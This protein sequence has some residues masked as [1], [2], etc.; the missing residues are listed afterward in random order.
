MDAIWAAMHEHLAQ[1][2]TE[3][4]IKAWITPLVP[5]KKEGPALVLGCP[6]RFFL[7]WIQEHYLTNLVAAGKKINHG[8]DIQN[9]RLVIAPPENKTTPPSPQLEL[10]HIAAR[11]N[12]PLSF[13]QRFTFDRFVV[14]Q[15]NNFAYSASLALAAGSQ[16]HHDALFLL[17]QPGLGK[18]HLSQ[19]IGHHVLAQAPSKKVFYLTAE[20]F[21]NEMVSSIKANQAEN[22]K[23][24]FRASCDV[25]VLEEISFLAGKDKIQTELGFT[26]DR[27]LESGKKVVFT[28]TK[29]PKDIPRL[30]RSLASR[31]N[32]ALISTIESPDFET[33]LNILRSKAASYGLA[34]E[35]NILGYLA[36]H[37]K[38]DVRQLESA[39]KS[40]AAKSH[41]LGRRLDMRLAQEV[42]SDLVKDN[43]AIDAETILNLLCRYYKVQA[44]EITSRSR[45]KNITQTRNI[46]MYLFRRLT[47]YPLVAIGRVFNRNHATVLYAINTLEQKLKVDNKLKLQVEFL[48]NQLRN[49]LPGRD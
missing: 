27:L 45:R 35:E 22:F 10:P 6:N 11:T 12:Q 4:T 32:S 37:L 41:L 14:G 7:N 43:Q 24:K 21:T 39:L 26:L 44:E 8:S 40:L 31:L 5:L 15:S 20:D 19:A 38:Q 13:N 2:L 36:E 42:I 47:D 46:G 48:T 25:L 29:L 33:R 23:N 17:A 3:S 9:I 16:L 1:E 34:T 28:S 18:S 30:R 49:R